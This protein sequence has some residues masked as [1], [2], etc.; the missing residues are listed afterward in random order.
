MPLFWL[1]LAF[2]G[3]ILL[4]E[5]LNWSFTTWLLLTGFFL[6]LVLVWSLLVRRFPHLLEPTRST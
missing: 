4:G 3:G 6:V 1:S 5:F 2:L